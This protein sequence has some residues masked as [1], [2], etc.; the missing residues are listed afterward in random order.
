MLWYLHATINLPK[1]P[2]PRDTYKGR[3]YATLNHD[4]L[5]FN[6]SKKLA[7]IYYSGDN[8]HFVIQIDNAMDEVLDKWAPLSTRI[9]RVRHRPKWYNS[10]VDDARRQRRSAERKWRNTRSDQDLVSYRKA[11][12]K[13]SCAVCNA[14]FDYLKHSLSSSSQKD[15]YRSINMLLNR[16]DRV[17][18]DSSSSINLASAFCRIFT[19]KIK[20]IRRVIDDR[21]TVD[22]SFLATS[23]PICELPQFSPLS[24]EEV[25]QLVNQSASKSS[26]S[27]PVPS[28]LIK[29]H[30]S[31]LLPALTELINTSLTTRTFP[32][33][34]SM[35]IITPVLKKPSLDRND[36]KTIV[37]C[38]IVGVHPNRRIRNFRVRMIFRDNRVWR[39]PIFQSW[40]LRFYIWHFQLFL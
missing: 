12:E 4:S 31:S 6:L 24:E 29:R 3:K 18:P 22:M 36:L 37:L 33:S 15:I 16:K 21:N 23:K 1:P 8:D 11:H 27:D 10:A 2:V 32:A 28:W 25:Q 38:Q 13:V 34:L 17:L 14:K 9:S 7:N 39:L 26:P 40:L 35:A 19:T 30:I 20:N 5:N